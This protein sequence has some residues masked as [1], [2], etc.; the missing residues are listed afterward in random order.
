M[1][2]A[3]QLPLGVAGSQAAAG[4]PAGALLL[5]ELPEDRLHGLLPLGVA[6]LALLAAEL[7]GHGGAQT[8]ALGL[9]RLAVL[10]G[11]ALAG[12]VGQWISSSGAPSI[13]VRLAIDQ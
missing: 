11:L 1:G 10:A 12:V 8:I 5:L 6:G 9:R 3:Q 7:G 4:E 13:S 2:A